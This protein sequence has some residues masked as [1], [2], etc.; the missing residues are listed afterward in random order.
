[1]SDIERDYASARQRYADLGVDAEAALKTL[2]MV[3]ISIPCWQGDDVRGF[4]GSTAD[5]GGGLAV[6]GSYKGRARNA[7]ELRGDF[8]KALSLIPGKHRINIH[9]MYGEFGGQRID[10]NQISFE[11]FRGWVD[12][13][14][15]LGLG[16]DFNP[17]CFAHEKA[18]N[19]FTLAHA[20]AGVRNFWIEHCRRCRE[21]ASQIGAALSSPSVNNLWVPDGM[22]DTPADRLSPRRRLEESLDAI[23]ETPNDPRHL[24]DSLES[25]LFG[26][27]S[28]SYVAGS[29]E[30]YLGYAIRHRKLLCLDSG[31]FHPTESVADKIS[32]LL[33]HLEGLLLH[34]SR[35]VR[36]DSDHIVILDDPVRDIAREVVA[37]GFLDRVH[38]GLDFFDASINRVA[39][40][41]IG[42]RSV[43]KALLAAL[44]E[45]IARLRAAE[46]AG[47]YTTRL[48]LQEESRTLPL[49]TVWD[50]FCRRTDVPI[51]AGWLED[52]KEYE[53]QVQS[54]RT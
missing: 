47:D 18:A 1:M 51:G 46:A 13:A 43:Q 35:P 14:R 52:V 31:H 40:W 11:H 5:L 45:P 17:T 22:K 21:V 28:E 16:I 44:L 3:P 9:A 20:D 30:F 27:G 2:A 36:W 19:G 25:K 29:H 37:N 12:W 33:L 50:E 49:G 39:A 26:I 34:I 6:T 38:I 15:S 42:V 7:D 10:R 32:A 8:E 4:E 41:V 53:L 23:F 54:R 48:A 24:L